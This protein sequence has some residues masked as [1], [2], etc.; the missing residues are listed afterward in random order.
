M[1]T[2]GW[3]AKAVR[4]LRKIADKHKRQSIYAEVQH[5]ASWPDVRVT[6]NACKVATVSGY[7]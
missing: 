1:D 7:A 4:Q 6:S 2:I 3:S 5:L